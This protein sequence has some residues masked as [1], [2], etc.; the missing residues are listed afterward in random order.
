VEAESALDV[1]GRVQLVTQ[2][3]ENA[4]GFSSRH[5]AGATAV[6]SENPRGWKDPDQTRRSKTNRFS[7]WVPDRR[8]FTECPLRSD[9]RKI[10]TIQRRLAW[11]L[12]KDDTLFQ[13]GRP[14]GLNIYALFSYDCPI[15]PPCHGAHTAQRMSSAR[16]RKSG[17][18]LLLFL[19]SAKMA[20]KPASYFSIFV[21]RAN[22]LFSLK[23][24]WD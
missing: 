6:A 22:M 10:G 4:T 11:P 23:A 17:A 8:L 3:C 5:E 13:S 9:I 2:P 15:T 21:G 19:R 20:V 12:H 24:H 1:H 14:S 18:E 7:V 16:Y